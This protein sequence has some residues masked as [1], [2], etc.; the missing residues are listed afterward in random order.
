M[1]TSQGTTAHSLY[2]CAQ[3]LFV[4]VFNQ[5]AL[6]AAQTDGLGKVCTHAIRVQ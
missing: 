5:T 2:V 1:G 3:L 4:R 6:I